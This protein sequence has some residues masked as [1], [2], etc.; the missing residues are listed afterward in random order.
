MAER[1]DTTISIGMKGDTAGGKAVEQQLDAIGKKAD[2][3]AKGATTSLGRVTAALNGVRGAVSKV[4]GAFG[5][6]GLAAQGVNTLL[7]AVKS[8]AGST[9]EADAA[10]QKT[11]ESILGVADAEKQ[12]AEQIAAANEQR[13][14]AAEYEDK[15]NASAREREKA[16]IE[17]RE[18]LELAGVS[19]ADQDLQKERIRQKYQAIREGREFDWND[20]DAANAAKRKREEAAELRKQAEE[21]WSN[22]SDLKGT[23]A[24][25]KYSSQFWSRKAVERSGR[26][27]M[28][29]FWDVVT[30]ESEGYAHK[31]RNAQDNWAAADKEARDAEKK[32]QELEDRAQKLEQE[33]DLDDERR[34]T[35]SLRRETAG[36]RTAS[37]EKATAAAQ[38]KRDAQRDADLAIVNGAPGERD[39]IQRQIDEAQ[40]RIGRANAKAAAA[41]EAAFAA[42][43]ARDGVYSSTR[44]GRTGVAKRREAADSQFASAQQAANAAQEEA[45]K[46]A[47]DLGE[48]IKQLNEK[49]RRINEAEK[50]AASRLKA[51]QAESPGNQQ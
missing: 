11:R 42:G 6:F 31:A 21:Q 16:E 17:H 29:H 10:A 27:G 33:A 45:D 1:F 50:Q 2:G 35:N 8:L 12:I 19:G 26:T 37:A 48:L 40:A 51:S 39:A 20:E 28:A 32:A 25:Q 7:E 43:N 24:A 38:S 34:A 5:L 13:K 47:R 49:L 41:G 9:S 36:L 22:V 30:G 44:A 14:T 3:V 4:M 18:A 23:A 15:L 46:I